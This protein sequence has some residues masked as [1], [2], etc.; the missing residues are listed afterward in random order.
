MTR[1]EL[2]NVFSS[3]RRAK[4]YFVARRWPDGVRCPRCGNSHVYAVTFRPY[5]W[6][7]KKHETVYRFSLYVGTIFKNTNLPL[8][9]W[10]KVLHLMLS[11]REMDP[12]QIQ[13]TLSIGSYQTAV[14]MHQRLRAGLSDPEFM[15][16]VGL[17]QAAEQKTA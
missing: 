11:G 17:A 14:H 12:L 8:V 15:Q 2:E 10:L 4:E 13:R 7:C 5:H 6:I 16:F 1:S 9:K 3:E